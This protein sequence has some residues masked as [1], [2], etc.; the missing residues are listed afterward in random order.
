MALQ[1]TTTTFSFS[2]PTF[3][4]TPPHALTSKRR[5][6]IKASSSG[7]SSPPLLSLS[8]SNLKG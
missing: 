4:S 1:A 2:A 8:R 3:R 6:S 5:I 7:L